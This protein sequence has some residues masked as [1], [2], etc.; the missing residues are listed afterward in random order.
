MNDYILQHEPA[1][2]LVSF[3]LILTLMVL[4]ETLAPRR[5][6]SEA[7][8]RHLG[9]N[10]AVTFI[11]AAVVRLFVPMLPVAL[12][13]LAALRG[14]G[15]F[16]ALTWPTWLEVALA[17]VFFDFAIYY[18][19]RLFHEVPLLWRL[20]KVHHS[21]LDFDTSTGVRFHP[22]EILLSLAIK[23]VLV[24][25]L[26]PAPVAVLLFEV[27]LNATALFNH[28]NVRLPEWLDYVLRWLLVTPD[29][30]RV[31]HSIVGRETNSNYGFNVPWWDRWLG[32]YRAQPQAG[33]EAMHIGIDEYRRREQTTLGKLL[34]MPFVRGKTSS[35]DP[36]QPAP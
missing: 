17:I 10:L 15:L 16:N 27:I 29:M 14:W 31:H 35:N 22:V 6:P 34:L 4:W 13:A 20:H 30:H 19:H 11:D 8:A 9:R 24:V 25:V 5:R 33:H 2:R 12:A 28:G 36:Q 7:R 1:I 21:D 3:I 23:S 18:Q 32:T 26:G